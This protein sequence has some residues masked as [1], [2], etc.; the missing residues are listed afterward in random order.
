MR[1]V[2][3]K[4]IVDETVKKETSDQTKEIKRVLQPS[5]PVEDVIKFSDAQHEEGTNRYWFNF[6]PTWRTITNQN[7]ILGVRSTSIKTTINEFDV[8]RP[9]IGIVIDYNDIHINEDVQIEVPIMNKFDGIGI[10]YKCTEDISN[11]FR[12][13]L[14]EHKGLPFIG[15]TYFYT[16]GNVWRPMEEEYDVERNC[17]YNLT[18]FVYSDWTELQNFS[19]EI[20]YVSQTDLPFDAL[21]Q[22]VEHVEFH[23][24]ERNVHVRVPRFTIPVVSTLKPNDIV[25]TASFANQTKDNYIGIGSQTFTPIKQYPINSSD[26]KFWIDLTV[27][28]SWEDA[29]FFHVSGTIPVELNKFEGMSSLIEIQLITQDRSQYI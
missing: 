5:I 15:A 11:Y 27:H 26:S 1:K 3:R 24:E 6:P 4:K 7:L 12:K 22:S 13:L 23:N 25:L 8:L 20:A 10:L 14:R 18:F 9:T 28:Q 16:D 21:I 29:D 19:L 2:G 17:C